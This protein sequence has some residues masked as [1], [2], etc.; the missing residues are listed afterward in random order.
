MGFAYFC[1][2]QKQ[3]SSQKAVE[4]PGKEKNQNMQY[5]LLA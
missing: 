4:S 1:T 5:R 3:F 2:N